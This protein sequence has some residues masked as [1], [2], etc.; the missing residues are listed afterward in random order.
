MKTAPVS[1]RKFLKHS[2]LSASALWLAVPFRSWGKGS[3]NEKLNIGFV[4]VGGQGDF[5]ISNLISQN[6]A[7]LC[8]VDDL[9]L[10]KAATRF[11]QAKRYND[12]RRLIDQ[13]G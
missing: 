6:I 2:A 1:R 13:K 5:S 10:D 3:P 9:R 8:D 12:F 11:P 7:A 4:G